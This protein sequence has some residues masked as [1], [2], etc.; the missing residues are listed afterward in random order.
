MSILHSSHP[1]SAAEDMGTGIEVALLILLAVSII[2][3]VAARVLP[4]RNVNGPDR[5]PTDKPAWVLV[6][7][8]LG[9]F[10]VYLFSIAAYSAVKYPV[11]ANAPSPTTPTLTSTADMA[12]LSTVP[13][14]LGF[15]AL[16]I[17]GIYC[18]DIA[19]QDLGF[20]PRRLPKGIARGLLGSLIIVPALFLFSQATDITYRMVHYEHPKEHPLLQA[21]GSRPP[22]PVLAALVIGACIVAPLFEELVFRGYLQ[23]LL[24]RLFYRIS[25]LRGRV[26]VQP[27]LPDGLVDSQ[28]TFPPVLSYSVAADAPTAFG[29]WAAILITAAIFALVHPSWSRP[30]IF[31]LAVCL[32]YAYERTGNLW[33]PITM[34]AAFNTI[35]TALFLAGFSSQ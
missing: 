8:M 23:T 9:A 21:M 10:G 12:F 35:S 25:Q 16:V 34:H 24:R 32:G 27:P 7:V 29:T 1:I 6:G 22:A 28:V 2:V 18:F 3:A 33:V 4:P 31:V 20:G 26:T 14:F 11:S 30:I 13:P 5:I 17:G 19:G 15:V